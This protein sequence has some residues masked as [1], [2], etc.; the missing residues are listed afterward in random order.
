LNEVAADRVAAALSAADRSHPSALAD[1]LGEVRL[2][3]ARPHL[4]ARRARASASESAVG[5]DHGVEDGLE[6]E[7]IQPP[8]GLL[9][10][11][12]RLVGGRLD[13]GRLAGLL[14]RAGHVARGKA[15]G[16]KA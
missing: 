7:G 16:F 8:I 13:A 14:G 3:E 1:V 5:T 4:A 12:K 6:I 9:R 11:L 15:I 10:L 2:V